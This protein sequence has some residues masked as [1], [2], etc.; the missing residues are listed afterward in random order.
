M[1][2]DALEPLVGEWT[3]IARWPDGVE[4]HGR[5]SFAWLDGGG[6]LVQRSTV[7]DPIPDSI[8][9]IGPD[10]SG[11]RLV[12]HYF[13]TRGVARVYDLGLEERVLTIT[14][15][16]PDVDFA[17][18]FT[19]RLSPDGAVIEGAWEIADDGTTLRHDF[20]LT[21]RRVA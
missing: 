10:A 20:A 18:R 14:R 16:G 7:D 5:V 13:D 12:Q 1:N 19:G 9:V 21:Y 17:Q 6:Y 3:Q 11:A 2:L 8:S 4:A 15:A